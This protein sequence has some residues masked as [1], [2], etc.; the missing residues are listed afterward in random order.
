MAVTVVAN[1]THTPT[2][3]GETELHATSTAGVYGYVV[4]TANMLGGDTVTLRV[5][6]RGVSAGAW[7]LAYQSSFSHTQGE[8]AKAAP[9]VYAAYGYRATIQQNAGTFRSFPWHV[10]S[11]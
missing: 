2:T 11:L 3:T 5:Y 4:D 1:G 6:V 9:A 10:V 8:P 7:R